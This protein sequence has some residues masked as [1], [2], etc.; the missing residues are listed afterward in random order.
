M[1]VREI[2]TP[3]QVARYLQVSVETVYRYIRQGK[4]VAS[5]VGRQYRIPRRN[6]EFFLAANS[7]V[8]LA[9]LRR[10]TL[11]R[12]ERFPRDDAIDDETREKG[13]RFLSEL[14]R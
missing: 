10:Y 2:M 14:R 1:A 6:V 12:V 3:E 5:K 4:L 13:D 11:E 9:E 7:T 8:P